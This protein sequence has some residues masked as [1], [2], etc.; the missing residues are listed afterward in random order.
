ENISNHF[1][2]DVYEKVLRNIDVYPERWSLTT[3]QFI[4]SYSAN[5]VF[6]CRSENFG[7]V[8]LKLGNPQAREIF[9]EFNALNEYDGKRF[10]RVFEADI[11]NGVILEEWIKPGIP[12]RDENNLEKRLSVFSS[13]YN[14]LHILPAKSEIYPTYMDW[15]DKITAYMSKRQDCKELYLY[16]KKARDICQSLSSTYSQKVLLHG[17]FHHDNILLSSDGE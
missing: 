12:L 14:D 11:E 1:G 2:K 17:D 16:M 15:V 13:L 8:V 9:T 4:P 7:D 5:L 3:F 6:T 10:C